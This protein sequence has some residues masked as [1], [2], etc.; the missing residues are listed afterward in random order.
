LTSWTDTEVVPRFSP[1][2]TRP[3]DLL[4]SIVALTERTT[5]LALDSAMEAAQADALGKLTVVVEQV[6]R[7]AVS[8]GVAAGE[9]GW[10]VTE[11]GAAGA[12]GDQLA[13]A[14][15]AIAGLQSSMLSVACAV[16]EFSTSGGPVELRSSAEALRRSALQLDD[17]LAELYPTA[18]L[19]PVSPPSPSA[20]ASASTRPV[21]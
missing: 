18:S 13:Q 10:L 11:L 12:N 19:N 16:Q 9:I 14:G 17:R 6:C 7:L 1:D 21:R 8:A 15:V 20:A 3:D 2:P 4:A 5:K